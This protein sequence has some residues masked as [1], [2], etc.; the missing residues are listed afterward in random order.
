MPRHRASEDWEARQRRGEL[1][2]LLAGAVFVVLLVLGLW[3]AG[4]D[5]RAYEAAGYCSDWH[6]DDLRP[7]LGYWT[8]AGTVPPDCK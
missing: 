1:W 7:G 2:Q 5:A 4:A 8:G 6:E 3:I